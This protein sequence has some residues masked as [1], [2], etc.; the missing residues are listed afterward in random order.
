MTTRLLICLT[1]WSLYI[2]G[3]LSEITG[4]IEPNP[5]PV[6]PA[7]PASLADLH[8]SSAKPSYNPNEPIPLEMTIQVG[9]FDLL[10]P[11][12]AVTGRGAF[13]KLVVKNNLGQVVP[14]K[15]PIT[16]PAKTKTV[17][18]KDR[19]V[20]CI[21]GT[22]LK[23][24]ETRK[25]MLK[26]LKTY[27][28]LGPGDYTLQILMELKVYREIFSPDPPEVLDIKNEIRIVQA[29][30]SMPDNTKERMIHNLEREIEG[31]QHGETAK[32]DGTYLLL[33]SYRGLATL[34]SKVVPLTIQQR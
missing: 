15:P 31:L 13:A 5:T 19:V 17:M 34:E 11:Y 30:A 7:T 18:W 16:F 32:L 20:S 22:E 28:K 2:T 27:Y 33:D 9:K 12:V 10:V 14:P 1:L 23:A 8:L 25:A 29:D 24:G 26:D 4:K 3:C 21:Q 6:E